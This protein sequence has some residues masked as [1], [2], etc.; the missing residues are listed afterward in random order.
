M[1]DNMSTVF[2]ELRMSKN[3]NLMEDYKIIQLSKDL[4]IAAPKISEL[5]NGKRKASLTEL[6]AY[7]EHFNVPYEYLLGENESPYYEY[8]VASKEIGLNGDSLKILHD[9]AQNPVYARIL[10]SIIK[11]CLSPLLL[12]I[13]IGTMYM[14]GVIETCEN[15][16]TTNKKESLEIVRREAMKSLQKI[17]DKTGEIVRL[18]SGSENIEYCKTRSGEIMRNAVGEILYYWGSEKE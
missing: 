15:H 6:K 8:M 5:E 10:N 1:E 16:N 13:S 12:E 14:D 17:T 3:Q 7:H 4:G 11:R 2:K 9:L 18:I